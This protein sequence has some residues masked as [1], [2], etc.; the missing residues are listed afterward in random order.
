MHDT[1]LA[2]GRAFFD[3]YLPEGAARILD[4][5]AQDINGSLRACAPHSASYLGVD[6]VPGR[7]V[8]LVLEDPHVLPFEDEAF[9]AVVT[10]SC[11]EHDRMFWVTF[12]EIIRVTRRGGHVYANVPSNGWFH[13]HPVD[14][15]RFYP[16]AGLGLQDWARRQG[17][18]VT[19]VESFTGRRERN[20]WND[21]VMV[22]RRG[23]GEAARGRIS[24]IFPGVMNLRRGASDT[25][26]ANACEATEDQQIILRLMQEVRQR[27]REIAELRGRLMAGEEL[28]RAG[29]AL[30]VG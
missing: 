2:F 17:Y 9:D 21:T 23:A 1:A 5:G 28:P 8:D 26:L 24:D 13:R 11:F 12:L 6:M 15:W 3:A 7:G 4:L 29:P 30:T 18:D 20:I 27:D 14:C 10:T 25:S 16:D 19:L 22:F